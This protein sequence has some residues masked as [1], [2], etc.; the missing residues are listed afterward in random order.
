MTYDTKER[1]LHI[2]VYK[3]VKLTELQHKLLICL[4][5]GNATDYEEIEKYLEV[6]KEAL[7]AL[8]IRLMQKTN[9][10]LKIKTINCTGYRLDNE[11]FFE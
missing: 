3:K 1:I 2:G 4:S 11:L 5:L 7:S 8:K 10:E 9:Y 6:S